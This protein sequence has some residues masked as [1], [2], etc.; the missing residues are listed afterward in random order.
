[1]AELLHKDI[2]NKWESEKTNLKKGW[3]YALAS[4]AIYYSLILVSSFVKNSDVYVVV[5][6]RGPLI[7]NIVFLGFLVL[8][9]TL[10]LGWVSKIL[11]EKKLYGLFKM[12]IVTVI[13]VVTV[14]VSSI[15]LL[16]L[17]FIL[18]DPFR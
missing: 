11:E 2:S 10:F 17:L 7:P 14:I 6:L 4:I 9:L 15:L 18:Q 1:M 8:F 16:I 3:P 12:G 13:G 5:F